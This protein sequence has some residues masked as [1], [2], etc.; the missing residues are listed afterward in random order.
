[1]GGST[2]P[3]AQKQTKPKKKKICRLFPLQQ[4]KLPPQN[5]QVS[6]RENNKSIMTKSKRREGTE[7]KNSQL[8][9]WV[10]PARGIWIC[11]C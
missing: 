6:L 11:G 9:K 8:L 7:R 5:I 1:M 4:K 10:V 3:Y 2:R